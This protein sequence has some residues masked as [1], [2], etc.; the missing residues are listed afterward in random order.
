LCLCPIHL[1][2]QQTEFL[3][4]FCLI[5]LL[6]QKDR[7]KER[8]LSHI[9][10]TT[11]IPNNVLCPIHL[12]QQKDH[13][14]DRVFVV[15]LLIH[16]VQQKDQTKYCALCHTFVTRTKT[17]KKTE[18]LCRAFGSYICYEK[19]PNKRLCLVPEI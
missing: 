6:R 9:F 13:T 10:G 15:L 8:V 5:H 18:F 14:K 12:L 4:Y 11:K 2:K 1:L 17:I 3:S 16:L 19:R 7:T